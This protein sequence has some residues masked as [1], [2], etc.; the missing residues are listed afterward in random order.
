MPTIGSVER[1]PVL[2]DPER[3]RH[4]AVEGF[5]TFP[6]LGR[7]EAEDLRV[8]YW[9][10]LPVAGSGMHVEYMQADRR[11][12][13]AVDRLLTPVW[14]R[15]LG[16]VFV[17]HRVV[18]TT[19]VV[20]FPGRDSSMFLHED[21]TYVDEQRY[22]S[23]TL[24]IPL[25][26]TSPA[27][28][29]GNLR[30]VPGS[31]RLGVSPS[32]TGTP[33]LFRPYERVLADRLVDVSMTA[34]EGLLYD[35]R[36][37]HASPP[38]RTDRPREAIACALVPREA[39]LIHV[40]A[41]GRSARRVFRVDDAFYRRHRPPELEKAMP[42]GY[43]VAED[44]HDRYDALP[45]ELIASVTG[46]EDPRPEP[47]VVPD[48]LDL[49]AGRA[50]LPVGLRPERVGAL[51]PAPQAD[52]YE[53]VAS[54]VRIRVVPTEWFPAAVHPLTR[55]GW[56]GGDP[57]LCRT[58]SGLA[59]RLAPGDRLGLPPSASGPDGTAHLE[60]LEAPPVGAGLVG[61]G[62][63]G[64]LEV[65]DAVAVGPPGPNVL[66]NHGPGDLVVVV[67]GSASRHRR[68]W[69]RRRRALGAVDAVEAELRSAV[70]GGGGVPGRRGPG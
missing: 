57:Q 54:E 51:V 21:R 37:L 30:I 20:K 62:R 52:G 43:P 50:V 22:R 9:D 63:A 17:D 53:P 14:E 27:L 45:R 7:A 31:Q 41:T 12:M 23:L 4:L 15:H 11:R 48:L 49:L 26:D 38:N 67:G 64:V 47:V 42:A 60:V 66:W 58:G 44:F 40:V 65:G 69:W 56:L 46:R 35:T 29:N 70:A 25:V 61:P 1:S 68:R 33:E 8:A 55:D 3:D 28:G 6:F 13:E 5:V 39:E 59:L 18:F 19:F 2:R 32:G 36:T 16:E 34:G 24:W 10:A